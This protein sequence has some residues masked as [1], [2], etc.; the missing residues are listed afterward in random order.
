MS[1][2][3]Q[4]FTDKSAYEPLW[5]RAPLPS[6]RRSIAVDPTTVCRLPPARRKSGSGAGSLARRLVAGLALTAGLVAIAAGLY[7]VKS[8]A[9]I[10]LFDG[11]SVFHE[12]LYYRSR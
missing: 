10:D 12:L 6:P 11:P 4:G 2:P 8:A 1:R 3:V 9:G 5:E 7:V